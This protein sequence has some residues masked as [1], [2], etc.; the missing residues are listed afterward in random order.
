MES[1]RLDGS[2][3]SSTSTVSSASSPSPPS[4]SSSLTSPSISPSSSS[5]HSTKLQS[6][7]S[8]DSESLMCSS[9]E[10]D[11]EISLPK[12]RQNIRTIYL[13]KYS[14]NKIK[15]KYDRKQIYANSND[16]IK[17]GLGVHHSKNDWINGANNDDVNSDSSLMLSDESTSSI[18]IMFGEDF[19]ETNANSSAIDHLKKSSVNGKNDLKLSK[20]EKKKE[21]R[22]QL[23]SSSIGSQSSSLSSSSSNLSIRSLLKDT[24]TYE[25]LFPFYN[26]DRDRNANYLSN[27]NNIPLNPTA[28]RY[29]IDVV[30]EY[31]A[32]VAKS[33]F[34]KFEKECDYVRIFCPFTMFSKRI[35]DIA[36]L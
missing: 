18:S 26:C 8:S 29:V 13:S 35:C 1:L 36:Q 10:E 25:P 23:R 17:Y 33:L 16:N 3:S 28:T 24:N 5:F 19:S 34:M 12:R 30:N 4:S 11:I 21:N 27:S 9:D 6:I 15:P 14:N 22:T 20:F 2:S 32:K 7:Y 31:S